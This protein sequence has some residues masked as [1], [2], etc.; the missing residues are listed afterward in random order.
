MELLE[1][2]NRTMKLA[3]DEGRVGS[4]EEAKILFDSFRL[5]IQVQPGFSSA[6]ALEA[7]V[8][9]LLNAAPKTFLGGVELVGPLYE[10]C[11]RAWFAGKTL[12][13][14]AEQF[15][16]AIAADNSGS[17][18][19]ICVGDGTPQG[20]GFWLGIRLQPAGFILSPDATDATANGSLES[21][22]EA[23]VASA[24]AALNEAF[25]HVYRNSPLAGQRDVRWKLPGSAN[26]TAFGSLWL[27]GL[28]HLGQAFLWTAALAGGDR[29]PRTIR[30]TDYD[31]V[32]WSSLSTC[33]LVAAK[34]VGRN[35]VD[36]V[37]EQ[38][39]SLG[40]HVQRNYECL[41][42]NSGIVR[43]EHEL[44]VVAVDNITLRRS[45]DRL[46][47]EHVLEAGIGDGSDAFTRIQLHSFPGPRKARDIWIDNDPRSARAVD[48]TKPAYQSLLAKSGDECGTTLVAGRSV[49][50]PFVGAFAGALLSILAIDRNND[51]HAWNYDVSNL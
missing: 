38:L 6:P 37:A 40:V 15:G 1:T 16:V 22:V 5:R 13:E 28:G 45:L 51:V 9:T 41:D 7:A 39:E 2:L 30:L 4:Y 42:F 10:R 19:I 3:M 24:G 49:A 47:A 14:V 26:P 20:C 31:T 27:V 29:L 48:L 23:G 44:V 18:P 21:P 36:V 25:Q 34:D 17:V 35:K 50:T 43:S 8:L 11:S 12:S 32:S 33:L 46:H